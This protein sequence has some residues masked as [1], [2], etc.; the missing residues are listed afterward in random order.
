MSH[1]SKCNKT[2]RSHCVLVLKSVLT[3]KSLKHMLC[4]VRLPFRLVVRAVKKKISFASD[5]PFCSIDKSCNDS[6]SEF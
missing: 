1:V 2:S 5:V 6:I 3:L 4:F